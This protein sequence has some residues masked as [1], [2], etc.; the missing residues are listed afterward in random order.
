MALFFS[1]VKTCS[2]EA[3][4]SELNSLFLKLRLPM[5][6]IQS[7]LRLN[8]LLDGGDQN[9]TQQ[10]KHSSFVRNRFLSIDLQ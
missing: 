7:T 4:G 1:T 8:E 2:R 9:L 5:K 6:A 3:S 10:L